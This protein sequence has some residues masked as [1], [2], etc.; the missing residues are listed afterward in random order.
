MTMKC[1]YCSEQVVPLVAKERRA[2]HYVCAK[3]TVDFLRGVVNMLILVM[4]HE[5]VENPFGFPFYMKK[6][7]NNGPKKK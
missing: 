7:E 1:Y 4:E 6:R 3:C 2:H 5:P